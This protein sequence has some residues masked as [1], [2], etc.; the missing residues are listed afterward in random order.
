MPKQY[1]TPSRSS[2]PLKTPRGRP[3]QDVAQSELDKFEA[4]C[5]MQTARIEQSL[6]R[7]YGRDY[8]GHQDGRHGPGNRHFVMPKD[9]HMTRPMIEREC[10]VRIIK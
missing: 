8:T 10:D 5:C 9:D 1:K 4:F 6:A 7:I 3:R 2:T